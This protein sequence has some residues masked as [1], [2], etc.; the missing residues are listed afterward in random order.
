MAS[1]RLI[2]W[3]DAEAAERAVALSKAGY[4]VAHDRLGS[5]TTLKDLRH[6]PP[7][8]FVIDLSRLPSHGRE[9]GAALRQSKATR[10]VPLVFVAGEAEKVERVRRMLPDATFTSWS[11]LRSALKRAIGAKGGQA[12]PIVPKSLSGAYSGTPLLKKL[13]VKPGCT[14][15]VVEPPDDVDGI[16]GALPE[17]TTLVRKPRKVCDLTLW[18]VRTQRD[19]NKRIDAVAK[20]VGSGGVWIIWPKKSSGVSSDLSQ[21]MIREAGLARGL[22]DYKICAVNETWSGLRFAVRR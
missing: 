20:R 18:F 10:F 15:G 1:I 11:R 12:S 8:A 19:L 9:I 16:L 21:Q 7:D 13:G 6:D 3:D 22:V 17:G 2:H 5:T 14:I 4:R